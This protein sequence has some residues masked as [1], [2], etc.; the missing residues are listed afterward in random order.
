MIHAIIIEDEIHAFNHLS[1]IINAHYSDQIKIIGTADS[2]KSGIELIEL[3]NPEL[4]FLDIQI[5]GGTGFDILDYFSQNTNFEIIFTTGLLDYKEKAMDYFAFYYL[6]KPIQENQFKEVIDRYLSKKSRFNL[7]NYLAF[8]HQIENENN[9]IVLPTGSGEFKV[10]KLDDITYC[11]ADGAYTTFYTLDTKE[12]LTSYNLAKFENLF[13]QTT[14]SRVHRSTLLNLRHV[15]EYSHL[16]GKVTLT[17][18]KTINI[19][20]RNKAGFL[21]MMKLMN[22]SL[23]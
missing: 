14:F 20:V 8:K 23:D 4:V 11:E 3:N 17:N 19:S 13:S 12:F 16:D 1:N 18:G 10:L 7:E 2:V 9:T 6:N 21:K 22:F 15:K 5:N